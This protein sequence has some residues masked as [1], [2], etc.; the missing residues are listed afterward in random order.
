[1]KTT[2]FITL[3]LFVCFCCCQLQVHAQEQYNSSIQLNLSNM[4]FNNNRAGFF[5]PFNYEGVTLSRSVY[6]HIDVLASFQIWQPFVK[7]KG[8]DVDNDKV[9]VTQLVGKIDGGASYKMIELAGKYKHRFN[10]H[11]LYGILGISYAWG[12]DIIIT[13]AIR[14]PGAFDDIISSSSFKAHYWG[15]LT[16]GGYNYYCSERISLGLNGGL[17]LYQHDFQ[18]YDIGLNIGYHFNSFKKS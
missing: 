13:G 9:P 4:S 15:L 1:M 16:S 12:D 11:E 14:Y 3:L 18:Q 5:H 10:R 2:S 17:R 6:K 8:Y 7:W